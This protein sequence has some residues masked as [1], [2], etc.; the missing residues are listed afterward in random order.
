MGV[1]SGFVRKASR[2]CA[3][4][5]SLLLASCGGDGYGGGGGGMGMAI[6]SVGG[7]IMGLGAGKSVVLN[8]N[9][10]GQ[11]LTVSADGSFTFSSYPLQNGALYTVTV[12]MQPAMQTCSVTNGG[13]AYVMNAMNV[14][15]VAV[16]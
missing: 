9:S 2:Y 4:A 1:Q 13:P 12:A 15:N 16:T 5:L 3:F 11:N 10:P 7:T 8:L 6:Y 14:T